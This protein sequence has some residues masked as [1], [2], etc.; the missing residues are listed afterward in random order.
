MT[1]LQYVEIGAGASFAFK[2]VLF[3]LMYLV[4]SMEFFWTSFSIPII[5]AVEGQYLMRPRSD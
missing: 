5:E 4:A 1:Y 3:L 2:M